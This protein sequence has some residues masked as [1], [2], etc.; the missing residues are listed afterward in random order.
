MSQEAVLG[1]RFMD[2]EQGYQALTLLSHPPQ[3]LHLLAPVWN[4]GTRGIRGLSRVLA[5]E[6]NQK[7]RSLLQFLADRFYDVEA[8]RDYLLR[9]QVL[10]VNQ[11]NR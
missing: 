3:S 4:G 11:K 1:G 7:E 8:L 2:P 5:P 9:K 10:K 6:G